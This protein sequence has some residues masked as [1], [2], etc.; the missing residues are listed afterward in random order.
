MLGLLCSWLNHSWIALDCN[1]MVQR[2]VKE[3]DSAFSLI[4]GTVKQ[5]SMRLLLGSM[6]LDCVSST[7]VHYSL[8]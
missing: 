7:R 3:L 1:K 2:L 5:F 6:F 4:L 8:S